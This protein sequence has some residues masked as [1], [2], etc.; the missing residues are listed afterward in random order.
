MIPGIGNAPTPK[1]KILLLPGHH[2]KILNWKSDHKSLYAPIVSNNERKCG[3]MVTNGD[4]DVQIAVVTALMYEITR[5]LMFWR[6]WVVTL[7]E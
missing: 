4:F 6:R 1:R 5:T 2:F 3:R 7:V